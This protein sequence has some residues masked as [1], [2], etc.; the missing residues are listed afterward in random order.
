[1]GLLVI[2]P[3]EKSDSKFVPSDFKKSLIEYS[4][5]YG[6]PMNMHAHLDRGY[7]FDEKYF[8]HIGIVPSEASAYPLS[9]KQHM[10]G[11]MHTGRAYTEKSL[12]ERMRRQ[13][14]E[15]A[16]LNVGSVWSA[17]D[18]TADIGL[19][20]LEAALKLKDEFKDEIDFRVG[21]YDIFGIKPGDPEREKVY[22]EAIKL[23]DFMVTLPERDKREGHIGYKPHFRKHLEWA[24]EYGKPIHFHVDQE[25]S[26]SDKEMGGTETIIDIMEFYANERNRIPEVWA[27]HAITP[28]S[29]DETRFKKMAEGLAKNKIGVVCCP[30]A[31]IS[32]YQN[33]TINTPTHN[34][35]AR[36]LELSL[37]GVDIA[38]GSDNNA[39]IFVPTNTLDL[40]DEINFLANIVRF[41]NA[42]IWAKI[43]T[44]TPLNEMDKE[45]VRKAVG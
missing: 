41:Y 43:L 39:D 20:A 16:G 4:K 8:D 6:K 24:I 32:M 28:A 10:T 22:L 1:M 17:I 27:V 21:A 11:Y 40:Y 14:E 37:A 31:G 12:K 38:I 33:R 34:S 3:E 25:S 30:S 26:T 44:R 18:T 36:V 45:I 9:V 19:I 15:S 7:T 35:I 5:K 13:L 42:G 23:A 2:K 29:Y